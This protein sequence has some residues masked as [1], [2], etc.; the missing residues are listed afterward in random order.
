MS[1]ADI[2][3]HP[4]DCKQLYERATPPKKWALID[5]ADHGFLSTG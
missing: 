1:S 3:T 4:D 5:G 2:V